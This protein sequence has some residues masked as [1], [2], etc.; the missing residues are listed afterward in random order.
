MGRTSIPGLACIACLPPA[1]CSGRQICSSRCDLLLSALREPHE[2]AQGSGAAQEPEAA[3]VRSMAPCLVLLLQL[4]FPLTGLIMSHTVSNTVS[5][6]AL[7]AGSGEQQV[8]FSPASPVSITLTAQASSDGVSLRL[9]ADSEQP[10][11]HSDLSQQGE[12]PELSEDD[13]GSCSGFSG[14]LSRRCHRMHLLEDLFAYTNS[15]HSR[16]LQY[17]AC[18]RATSLAS[19]AS[20]EVGQVAYMLLEYCTRVVLK[21][22]R[23]THL[24]LAADVNKLCSLILRSAGEV[25]AATSSGREAPIS[26]SQLSEAVTEQ[27]LRA[28][29]TQMQAPEEQVGTWLH[30]KDAMTMIMFR[31]RH[32]QPRALCI[33]AWP[34]LQRWPEDHVLRQFQAAWIRPHTIL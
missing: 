27:L 31:G 15:L 10:L 14:L 2:A 23:G 4:L 33:S 22:A 21:P 26:N 28:Q 18:M 20:D 9:E 8:P 24:P 13:G 30:G 7:S 5:C 16:L 25:L 17:N 32:W 12:V 3:Y 29:Q 19:A 1:H 34:S 11:P 6:R